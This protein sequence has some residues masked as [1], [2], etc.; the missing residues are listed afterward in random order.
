MRYL[1]PFALLLTACPK[2]HCPAPDGGTT[3]QEPCTAEGKPMPDG[4][5]CCLG[6][7]PGTCRS[8]ECVAD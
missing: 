8:H 4:F 1:L 3:L 7:Q 2:D 5:P 6:T